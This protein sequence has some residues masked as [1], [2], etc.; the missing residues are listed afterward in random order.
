MRFLFFEEAKSL[1]NSA[2]MKFEFLGSGDLVYWGHLANSD[3]KEIAVEARISLGDGYEDFVLPKE[4]ELLLFF[5]TLEMRFCA[6]HEN[7][8][9]IVFVASMSKLYPNP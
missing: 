9:D 3:G 7:F 2:M 6:E 1:L 5:N 4:T 8:Y